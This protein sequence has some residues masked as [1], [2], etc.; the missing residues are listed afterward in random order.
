MLRHAFD[1]GNPQWQAIAEQTRGIVFLS[2][3]HSGS[4]IASWMGYIGG[5]LGKSVSVEELEANHSRLR[6]LN[7]VYRNHERLK[8]VR[9]EVYCEKQKTRGFLVVDESSADPG[10]PGVVPI[11]IDCNHISIAKPESKKSLIYRR[12]KRFV[13]QS[14]Q[15]PLAQPLGLN[16]R[17][18][19][20]LGAISDGQR[21][22]QHLSEAFGLDFHEV[23]YYLEELDKQGL[24]TGIKAP[25]TLD[26]DSDGGKYLDCSLT[27]KGQVALKN[28]SALISTHPS[29]IIHTGGGNY[30]E[31]IA[32]N[33]IQGIFG[34]NATDSGT[35]HQIP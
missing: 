15:N 24:I 8:R 2:T 12:V 7:Q 35:N 22:E 29:R 27:S 16:D 11:P 6:E 19:Q 17:L 10:I 23:R 4:D 33:Y 5:I 25:G 32:G 30:N 1:Y 20:I 28:P 21:S 14:L 13:Q 3:P 34:G 9:M 18:F 26:S 31:Y